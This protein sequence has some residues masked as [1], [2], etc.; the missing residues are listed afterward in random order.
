M[1]YPYRQ[2]LSGNDIEPDEADDGLREAVADLCLALAITA[3]GLAI[4]LTSPFWW[5]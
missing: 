4:V 2:M 3:A 1:P 5:P